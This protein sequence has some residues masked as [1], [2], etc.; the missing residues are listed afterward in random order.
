VKTTADFVRCWIAI[1]IGSGATDAPG[2]T[3]APL[4]EKT[5]HSLRG[6]TSIKVISWQVE[7]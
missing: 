6:H 1:N 4:P 2:A 3:A 5:Q 7:V